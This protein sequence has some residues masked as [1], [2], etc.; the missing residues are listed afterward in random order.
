M[1]YIKSTVWICFFGAIASLICTG[2]V[3]FTVCLLAVVV[4]GVIEGTRKVVYRELS[5][6]A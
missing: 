3:L 4:P 1:W 6:D 2:R 5:E